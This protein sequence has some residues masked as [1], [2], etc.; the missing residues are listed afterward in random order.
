ML[1]RL[2]QVMIAVAL[3]LPLAGC[4][5][6]AIGDNSRRRA[7]ECTKCGKDLH[8]QLCQECQKEMWSDKCPECAKLGP[9]HMCPACQEKAGK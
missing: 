8:D 5:S 7:A 4:I 1:K 6:L 3:I 9:G 2:S